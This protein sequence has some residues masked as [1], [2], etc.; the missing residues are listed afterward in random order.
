M[1][2]CSG[3]WL[4][5]S[6]FLRSSRLTTCAGSKIAPSPLLFLAVAPSRRFSHRSGRCEASRGCV[7]MSQTFGPR[8]W[9]GVP[10]VLTRL[11]KPWRRLGDVCLMMAMWRQVWE[12]L[13]AAMLRRFIPRDVGGPQTPVVWNLDLESG[14]SFHRPFIEAQTPLS[15][16]RTQTS[17]LFAALATP[18]MSQVELL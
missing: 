9:R 11:S 7:T 8:L 1:G 10:V 18:S 12:R 3:L 15:L 14:T 2:V 5:P 16:C 17:T 13:K 6:S 4:P